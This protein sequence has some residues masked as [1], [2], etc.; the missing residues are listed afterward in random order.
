MLETAVLCSSAWPWLRLPVLPQLLLHLQRR[1]LDGAVDAQTQWTRLLE[2]DVVLSARV[3]ALQ[4]RAPTAESSDDRL[5]DC[6]AALG[7]WRIEALLDQAVTSQFFSVFNQLG[8]AGWL[9]LWARITLR[10]TFAVELA[11]HLAYP[12][13]DDLRLGTL[14][15]GL[16]ELRELAATIDADFATASAL[17]DP[18]LERSRQLDL[19]TTLLGVPRRVVDALHFLDE[20]LSRTR[21]AHPLIRLLRA[22]VDAYPV[23]IT[24]LLPAQSVGLDEI[25]ANLALP[26]EELRH[27]NRKAIEAVTV[28]GQRLELPAAFLTRLAESPDW[29]GWPLS[30]SC[31]GAS[32]DAVALS[33]AATLRDQALVKDIVTPWAWQPDADLQTLASAVSQ[34]LRLLAGV[35][36]FMLY[37]CTDGSLELL[38]PAAH[39]DGMLS[40]EI[41][42]AAGHGDSM[43]AHC[44]AQGVALGSWQW[45]A[46]LALLDRQLIRELDATAIF[47]LPLMQNAT[48]G[49]LLV[50]GTE[51]STRDRLEKRLPALRY[52]GLLLGRRLGAIRMHQ[53]QT[54]KQRQALRGQTSLLLRELRHELGSPLSIARNYLSIIALRFQHSGLTRTD[55]LPVEAEIDRVVELVDS[56]VQRAEEHPTAMA[57]QAF[58]LNEVV[59][60]LVQALQQADTSGKDVRYRLDLDEANPQIRGNPLLLRQVLINLLDNAADASAFQGE[61]TLTTY[62]QVLVDGKHYVELTIRDQGPGMADEVLSNLFKPIPTRKAPPHQGLGLSIVKQL[63]EQLEGVIELR[64]SGRGTLWSLKFLRVL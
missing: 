14:L 57:W 10:R 40:D 35:E 9:D 4:G 29:S 32:D 28:V 3:L 18:D 39:D 49:A 12:E 54:V 6:V 37:L 60:E 41:T 42:L 22:A 15:L 33:L 31:W 61:I 27:A 51:I 59:C 1:K 58:D 19:L 53:A 7:Q 25:A 36:R 20:P 17:E 13:L 2:S 23:A 43:V 21:N 26:S 11:N 44:L 47:C 8:D 52:Y 16:M 62:G 48:A 50:I 38:C 34:E 30:S 46:P 5:G 45:E 56:I 55:L 63:M 64:S 24:P